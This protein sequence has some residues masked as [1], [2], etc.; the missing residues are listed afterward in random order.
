MAEINISDKCDIQQGGSLHHSPLFSKISLVSH[1]TLHATR[2]RCR[3]K[4]KILNLARLYVPSCLF[5]LVNIVAPRPSNMFSEKR[6]CCVCTPAWLTTRHSD[7]TTSGLSLHTVFFGRD[8][9]I[10]VYNAGYSRP[11][12]PNHTHMHTVKEISQIHTDDFHLIKRWMILFW[13]S[14]KWFLKR[15]EYIS[16]AEESAMSQC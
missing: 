15:S 4:K 10:D 1:H 14:T 16:P 8:F 7:K 2:R 3:A 11:N 5:S 9:Q 13:G 6:V 12:K